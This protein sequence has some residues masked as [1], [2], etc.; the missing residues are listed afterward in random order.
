MKVSTGRGYRAL[1]EIAGGDLKPGQQVVT[2]GNEVL[3]D[4]AKVQ[5]GNGT[6]PGG[7]PGARSGRPGAGPDSKRDGNR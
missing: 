3:Q 5:L 2:L 6:R 4:G 1:L 7:R